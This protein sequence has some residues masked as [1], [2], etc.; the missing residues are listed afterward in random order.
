M[1]LR[2]SAAWTAALFTSFFSFFFAGVLD[3]AATG[4]FLL[5]AGFLAGALACFFAVVGFEGFLDF[6]FAA[7]G[8]LNSQF[9]VNSQESKQE[10]TTYFHEL[11]AFVN[12]YNAGCQ[13]Q[14][15]AIYPFSEHRFALYLDFY[16]SW[17]RSYWLHDNDRLGALLNPPKPRVA[18]VSQPLGLY[19]KAH[20]V[21]QRLDRVEL[22]KERLN[23]FFGGLARSLTM[24]LDGKK[25]LVI[26]RVEGRKDFSKQLRLVELSEFLSVQTASPA[27]NKSDGASQYP[28]ESLEKLR[29]KLQIALER[30][31]QEANTELQWL[32]PLGE[33]LKLRKNLW[34]DA[35]GLSPVLVEKVRHL[36]LAQ[37]LPPFGPA[38]LK[39]ANEKIFHALARAERK[40]LMVRARLEKLARG[41]L[42]VGVKVLKNRR[43]EISN[44]RD[45][46]KVLGRARPGIWVEIADNLWAR[47]GRSARE[48]DELFRQARDRDLWFHVRG[49]SGAHVWIPRGQPGLTNQQEASEEILKLGRMLALLNSKTSSSASAEVDQSERRHLKKI[50]REVGKLKI[51]RSRVVFTRLDPEFERKCRGK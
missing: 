32:R 30:D 16:P 38:Y 2:L 8:M 18:K 23:L 45:T 35:A 27:T 42:K 44:P 11:G 21:G 26:C 29:I 25:L 15:V 17:G 20:F 43:P 28:P 50:P 24:S 46:K 39:V 41:E 12:K 34:Q 6:V 1:A 4:L 7:I 40:V 31:L 22:D 37:K 49:Q 9:Q 14:D 19:L 51:V 13:L 3:F 48:N 5:L 33:E 10:S 36:Q 47:V